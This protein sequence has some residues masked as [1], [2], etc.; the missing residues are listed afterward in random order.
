MIE[1]TAI[2]QSKTGIP[3]YDSDT[4]LAYIDI[5]GFKGFLEKKELPELVNM[6]EIILEADNSSSYDKMLSIETKLISDSFVIYARITE[7]KQLSVFFTYLG[8]IIGRIHRIGD[9]VTRG[10]V[11]YGKHYSSEKLWISPVFVEAYS[12][13]QKKA[14]HPRVILGESA[15]NLIKNMDFNFIDSGW[16]MRDDDGF[17]YINYL[18]CIAEA[19]QPMIDHINVTLNSPNLRENLS[20]HKRTIINGL[21]HYGDHLSKYFWL[22]SYH[23][24]YIMDNVVLDNKEDLL[25]D[26]KGY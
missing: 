10:Y 15:E 5:L 14:I 19:Y 20:Q 23:N 21:E 12:G 8:T 2:M 7:A 22:A 1:N 3:E 13:E 24:T 17:R 4:M 16:F 26:L 6:I 9:I 25:I 18:M 11:A